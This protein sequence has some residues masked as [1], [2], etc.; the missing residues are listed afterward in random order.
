M[1]QVKIQ[2]FYVFWIRTFPTFGH[3][4]M[5]F[6]HSTFHIG[7]FHFH[8]YIINIFYWFAGHFFSANQSNL[9]NKIIKISYTIVS[10]IIR[11][12]IRNYTYTY[13]IYLYL[14]ILILILTIYLYLYL[15][16][17]YTYTYYILILI[18]IYTYTYTYIYLYLYLLYTY[19]YTYYILILIHTVLLLFQASWQ[20]ADRVAIKN[21][22]NSLLSRIVLKMKLAYY[23]EINRQH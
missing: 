2:N 3:S 5:I 20:T 8:I 1:L 19:T 16:Y 14:Y 17:T 13:T 7:Y 6:R 4:Y 18:L 11:V 9:D 15:L 10:L 23:R 12:S 21:A 22:W